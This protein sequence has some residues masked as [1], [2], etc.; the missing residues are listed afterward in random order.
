MVSISNFIFL[1]PGLPCCQ[2]AQEQA[3]GVEMEQPASEPQPSSRSQGAEEDQMEVD[4]GAKHP[5]KRRG[6]T[7]EDEDE[8]D[9][10]G[11]DEDDEA[12]GMP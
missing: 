2:A 8:D 10:A 3:D 4:G 11:Q 1:S 6:W 7:L 5:S 12:A 9:D